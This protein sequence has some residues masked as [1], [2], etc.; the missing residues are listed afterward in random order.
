[1]ANP[2]AMS[3]IIKSYTQFSTKLFIGFR[4]N[5]PS[6]NFFNSLLEF[7]SWNFR[8]L[9]LLPLFNG[10]NGGNSLSV[11]VMTWIKCL[12][13]Y[14]LLFLKRFLDLFFL[15]ACNLSSIARR[16]L[17]NWVVV[18]AFSIWMSSPIVVILLAH[19]H[20]RSKTGRVIKGVWY[21]LM[22][23]GIAHGL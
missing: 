3:H 8:S 12:D 1:M 19:G 16:R 5:K 4:L 11:V 18:S 6:L 15:T 20:F 14:F 23:L 13:F 10:D 21:V 22:Q 17:Q 2:K 9:F 7:W